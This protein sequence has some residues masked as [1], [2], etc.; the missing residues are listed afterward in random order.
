MSHTSP[1][2]LESP[3]ICLALLIPRVG[4]SWKGKAPEQSISAGSIKTVEEILKWPRQA[5]LILWGKRTVLGCTLHDLKTTTFGEMVR[6]WL[7]EFSHCCSVCAVAYLNEGLQ[8]TLEHD[9]IEAKMTEPDRG[10]R[11]KWRQKGRHSAVLDRA[12]SLQ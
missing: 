11:G 12:H 2:S 7:L 3:L 6:N 8:D 4:F 5:D 1:P 9:N 10:R